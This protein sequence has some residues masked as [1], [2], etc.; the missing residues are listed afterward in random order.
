M[1]KGVTGVRRQLSPDLERYISTVKECTRLPI[2]VGFGICD[3]YQA[4]CAAQWSDAVVVGSA[5]INAA[6]ER[7]LAAFVKKLSEALKGGTLII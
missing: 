1:V 3:D 7:R 5:L 6:R 4:K 2:A